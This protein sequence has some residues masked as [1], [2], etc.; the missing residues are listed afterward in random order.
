M[1]R[2]VVAG[3]QGVATNITMTA[4]TLPAIPLRYTSQT[5]NITVVTTSQTAD[6]SVANA[7]VLL[8]FDNSASPTLNTDLTVEVTC[9]GG[10]NWT[11]ASLSSVSTNG[12]GG[13]KIVETADQACTG[14]TSFAARIKTFNNKNVPIYGVSLTVR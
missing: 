10:T 5:S 7:R 11:A 14:G 6:S 3:N 12:Q 4:A 9:D 1:A 13:R 8:E 2:S